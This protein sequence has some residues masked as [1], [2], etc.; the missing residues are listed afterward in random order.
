MHA[1][2]DA[3]LFFAMPGLAPDNAVFFLIPGHHW[4]YRMIIF[5]IY[6]RFMMQ[7]FPAARARVDF[8]S[9]YGG[10]QARSCCHGIVMTCQLLAADSSSGTR[11][12]VARRRMIFLVVQRGRL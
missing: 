1:D 6:C 5:D 8:R 11:I 12:E 2:A 3:G 4:L 10:R 7:Y 9:A